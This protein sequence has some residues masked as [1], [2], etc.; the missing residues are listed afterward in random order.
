MAPIRVS[1]FGYLLSFCPFTLCQLGKESRKHECT[2]YVRLVIFLAQG[3][4]Y[5]LTGYKTDTCGYFCN[6]AASVFIVNNYLLYDVCLRFMP[7][8]TLH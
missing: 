8:F 4:Y 3:Y 7:D 6:S 1:R 2:K 5:M